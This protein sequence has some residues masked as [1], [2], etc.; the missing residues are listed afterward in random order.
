MLANCAPSV[1]PLPSAA[2]HLPL[3]VPPTPIAKGVIT[4]SLGLLSLNGAPKNPQTTPAV[5]VVVTVAEAWIWAA[6]RLSL[7]SAV[8]VPVKSILNIVAVNVIA[9]CAS[10]STNNAVPNDAGLGAP[11]TSVGT[12]GGVS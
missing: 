11:P 1:V 5:V 9:V 2:S 4:T 7:I 3:I 10:F 12:V 8:C 6:T